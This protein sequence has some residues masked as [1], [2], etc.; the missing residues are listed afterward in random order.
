MAADTAATLDVAHGA[1]HSGEE[2]PTAAALFDLIRESIADVLG[3]AAAAAML[4]RA[5]K[6]ALSRDPILEELEIRR[7]GLEYEYVQPRSWQ[8]G[9]AHLLGELLRD[10]R[11]LLVELTGA[12]VVLRLERLPELR[13]TGL[14][15]P[16]RELP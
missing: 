12:V 4:R 7:Q 10:L 3:S 15:S 6:R 13:R 14:F 11:P 16:E 2:S 9:G 1:R 5:A 8:E